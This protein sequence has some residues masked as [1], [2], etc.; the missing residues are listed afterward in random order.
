MGD[1]YIKNI[2]KLKQCQRFYTSLSTAEALQSDSSSST[3]VSNSP[4][5]CQDKE[6]LK[7]GLNSRQSFQ[8]EEDFRGTLT[9]T[10]RFILSLRQSSELLQ[11]SMDTSQVTLGFSTNLTGLWMSSMTALALLDGSHPSSM[12][13]LQTKIRRR[14]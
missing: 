7:L 9:T 3:K 4:M 6:K 1:I 10:V 14:Q 12:L 13:R 8:A 5:R 2:L 11:V